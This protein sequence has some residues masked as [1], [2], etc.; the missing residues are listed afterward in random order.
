MYLHMTFQMKNNT[1]MGR[2]SERKIGNSTKRLSMN[3]KAEVQ[4]LKNPA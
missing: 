2:N 4:S 1:E 3:S